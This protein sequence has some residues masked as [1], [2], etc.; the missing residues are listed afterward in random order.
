MAGPS[1]YGGC[2]GST[3][4]TREQTVRH[5]TDRART[6]RTSLRDRPGAWHEWLIHSINQQLSRHAGV[7][8]IRHGSVHKTRQRY[9]PPGG[10]VT[11]EA[12]SR[13]DHR[14]SERRSERHRHLFA[15]GCAIR[16]QHT[17]DRPADLSAAGRH[18]GRE[19]ENRP[20]ERPRSRDEPADAI[21]RGGCCMSPSSCCWR[22][23]R[24]ISQP[25]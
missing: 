12:R 16:L 22:R 1:Q 15:G 17:V 5:R 9:R 6:S 11:D 18:S 20:G 3:C 13:T 24:S 14:R 19:R 2:F 7:H 10:F 8:G 4:H 25:T 21:T 23:T